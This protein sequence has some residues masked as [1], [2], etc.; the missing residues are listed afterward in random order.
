[1]HVECEPTDFIA[2]IAKPAALVPPTRA[3]LTRFHGVFAPKAKWRAQLTPSGRGR[4]PS[5]DAEATASSTDERMP[6]ERRRSTT[7]ALRLE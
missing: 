3:Q 5:I 6:D 7:W 4:R 2:K 1:M